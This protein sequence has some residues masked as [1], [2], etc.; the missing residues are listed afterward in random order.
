[1]AYQQALQ[2]FEGKAREILA[3]DPIPDKGKEAET[4]S[5]PPAPE[6]AYRG[7]GSFERTFA[8]FDEEMKRRFPA[9]GV[10]LTA[11]EREEANRIS[12]EVDRLWLLG[13]EQEKAFEEGTS[14]TYKAFRETLITWF[15]FWNKAI[16]KKGI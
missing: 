7:A 10:D 1:M 4:A 8:R 12:E 13:E 3:R 14:D 15:M 6:E 11:E 5:I 9:S 2:R 16:T